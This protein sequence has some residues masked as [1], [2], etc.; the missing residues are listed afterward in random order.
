MPVS[1]VDKVVVDPSSNEEFQ[2]HGMR[3]RASE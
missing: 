1:E 3:N 2:V